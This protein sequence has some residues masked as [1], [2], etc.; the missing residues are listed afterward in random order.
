MLIAKGGF[1]VPAERFLLNYKAITRISFL[2]WGKLNF[3]AQV[4]A[5]LSIWSGAE[6][7]RETDTTFFKDGIGWDFHGGIGLEYKVGKIVLLK[8]PL[9]YTCLFKNRIPRPVS[10]PFLQRMVFSAYSTVYIVPLY[11]C[12]SLNE[13]YPVCV[14]A[15]YIIPFYHIHS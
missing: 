11:H 8:S 12:H 14:H 13:M 4:N 10:Y 15:V 6:S 9:A 2:V 5:G 3:L 1:I 7:T